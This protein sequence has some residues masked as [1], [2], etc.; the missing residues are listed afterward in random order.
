[1][2]DARVFKINSDRVIAAQHLNRYV[3]FELLLAVLAGEAKI[4]LPP[5]RAWLFSRWLQDT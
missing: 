1:M 3:P 5:H 2:M 4:R